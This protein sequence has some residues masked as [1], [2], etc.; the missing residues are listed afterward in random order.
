MC[1]SV[2]IA[3]TQE[4][5]VRGELFIRA[6]IALY[7][8]KAAGRGRVLLFDPSMEARIRD[9][10]ALLADLAHA[11]ENGEF[12]IAYQPLLDTA[13]LRTAGFE[14]LLRWRHSRRGLIRPDGLRGRAPAC[15]VALGRRQARDRALQTAGYPPSARPPLATDKD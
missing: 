13:S 11:V 1:A 10:W 8:A 6:D 7:D 4:G 2:G 9:R 3:S 12:E 5:T 14:A 15:C